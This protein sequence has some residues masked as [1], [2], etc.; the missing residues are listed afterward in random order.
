M[1]YPS[2]LDSYTAV[3]GTSLVATSDHANMHNVVGSASVAIETMLGANSGTNVLKNFTEG[4]L[5]ART[6]GETFG[7]S[8]WIGGTVGTATIGT[9]TITGG[10]IGTA[11]IR[12]GT[13]GTSVI[14][15]C[16]V[17]GGTVGT[18]LVGTSTINGGTANQINM[19]GYISP[20]FAT[21]IQAGANGTLDLTLANEFRVTFGTTNG[22]LVVAN[23]TDGQ[24]F[25]VSLT[26][27]AVGTRTVTWFTTIK[28]PGGT[29][30]TPVLTTAAAKRDTF[31]F[32]V[33]GSDQYDGF[34]VGQNL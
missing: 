27:D 4:K 30:G 26:Q 3:E 33:T 20:A 21:T 23:E 32:I 5:A 29:T 31:G 28:W 24:K 8:T 22:T 9:C 1:A 19:K 10:N 15:T 17:I 14:G 11:M 12:G 25:I 34:I 16:S 6:V 7:T 18:A 13:V 2:T